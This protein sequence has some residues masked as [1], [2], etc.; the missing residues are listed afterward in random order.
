MSTETFLDYQYVPM[1]HWMENPAE[2]AA[3]GLILPP[4]DSQTNG[5]RGAGQARHQSKA[6]NVKILELLKIF[7]K[8]SC[9]KSRSG[10]R[11]KACTYG[12]LAA[13]IGLAT[14]SNMLKLSSN[15]SK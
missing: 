12:L 6:L 3:L 5:Q 10:Q 15:A 14:N 4:A 1:Q 11:T 2:H 7:L 9:A 13:E 8:R